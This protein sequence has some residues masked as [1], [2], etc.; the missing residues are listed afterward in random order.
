MFSIKKFLTGNTLYAFF[1][2]TLI[3]TLLTPYLRSKGFDTLK[4][5]SIIATREISTF[6]CM[7]IGGILF[8]KFG[9][10]TTFLLGRIIDIFAMFL[11]LS[12]NVNC[13][14]VSMILVGAS[15]GIV[16]GKYTSYIYNTLSDKGKL[17]WYARCSASYYFAW[18]IAISFFGFC[19]A[20][21]LKKY[22]NN[23]NI[24]IY[25]SLIL[26]ILAIIS[27]FVFI[28]SNQNKNYN[29]NDFKSESIKEIFKTIFKCAKGNKLFVDLILFYAVLNFITWDL[30]VKI[31][32][33]FF[34]D[35]GWQPNSMASYSAILSV[36]MAVGTLIPMFIFTQGISM[37]KCLIL[38]LVEA[39]ILLISS[40]IYNDKALVIS[41]FLLCATFS[42]IEVSVE[43]RF[44]YV[45]N[46]KVRG[47]VVSISISIS[48][49]I[50]ILNTMLVGFLAK[51]S[52]YH[53]S[54]IIISLL[55]VIVSFYFF[56]AV[57]NKN[58]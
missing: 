26:K 12:N 50:T 33:M 8:D 6:I 29:Y 46:K 14:I 21:L 13:I 58:I 35:L 23:Y 32:D 54:A 49:I 47:S 25:M 44:E 4:L 53:L 15:Y 20:I 3:A 36:I 16:M 9:P 57:K 34:I 18:D 19:A 28:P 30:S 43:K 5:S 42:L 51:F 48:T 11:L 40:I 37:K 2:V 52:S 10:R 45:S 27:I 7:Y 38:N 22:N 39:I 55:M 24:L 1:N 17:N 41:F 31:G 56:F